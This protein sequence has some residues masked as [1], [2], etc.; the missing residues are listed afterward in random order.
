MVEDKGVTIAYSSIYGNTAEAAKKLGYLLG[1]AGE[2]V[3][4]FDLAR[5]DLA[6]AVESAFRYDRLVLASITY[7]GGLFPMT[8]LFINRLKSK[9]F[10][11]RTV[12]LIENGS[13]APASAKLMRA[14][15]ETMKN[16]TFTEKTITVKSAVSE[17][18]DAELKELVKELTK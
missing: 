1:Q 12:A 8:E 16:I 3:E 15:F 11:N 9:N 6:E 5:D 4:M 14:Q 13:W 10:Q 17:E 7:D 18:T 2:R